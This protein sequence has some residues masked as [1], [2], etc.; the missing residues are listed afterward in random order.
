[1]SRRR[2]LV[3]TRGL[4]RLHLIPSAN[5]HLFARVVR[6]LRSVSLESL[7]AESVRDQTIST[8]GTTGEKNLQA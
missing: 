5:I 2:A 8:R 6:H 7:L 1:M 4:V 3:L